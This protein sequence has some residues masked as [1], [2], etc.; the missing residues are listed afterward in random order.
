MLF[1]QETNMILEGSIQIAD[2]NDES[3]DSCTIRWTGTDFEG[4]NGVA[5]LS[6]T[7]NASIGFAVETGKLCPAG[8]HVPSDAEWTSLVDYL[9]LGVV[10]PDILVTQS[11][12]AGGKMKE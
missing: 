8:W 6:M 10:D 12:L 5:W 7:N 4:W 2:S 9:D 1:A 3:P 11:E